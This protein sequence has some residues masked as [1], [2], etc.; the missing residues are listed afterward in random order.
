[1]LQSCLT[2]CN[3]M[4]HSSPG[5]SV[6][7]IFQARTLGWIAMPSSRESSQPRDWTQVS[8][9]SCIGRQVLY[10]TANWEAINNI[11]VVHSPSVVS[12][13]L[14]PHGL[15]CDPRL[16]CP[17][18]FSRKEY[19]S[20]LP[21]PLPRGS[22]LAK[23]WIQICNPALQSDSL[24]SEPPGKPKN[25]GVDNLSRLQRIFLVKELN[26]VFCIA[27]GFFTS[28]APREAPNNV[29]RA[30]NI[31]SFFLC[32]ARPWG[33][34]DLGSLTRNW[35]WHLVMKAQNLNH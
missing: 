8:Y 31:F 16:L 35:A 34:W 14:W 3:A 24:L 29:Y 27:G 30:A 28:W 21:C 32:F 23:D 19:W 10:H 9:V 12:D 4:D 1:M 15:L 17:W 13:S 2:L 26:W 22:S 20:G 11:C 6:H 5:S 25:T 33:L 18:E 7:G